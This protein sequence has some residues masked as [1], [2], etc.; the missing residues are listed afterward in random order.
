V[1]LSIQG[2][3]GDKTVRVVDPHGDRQALLE[4]ITALFEENV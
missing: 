2:V 1:A 3:R 4:E